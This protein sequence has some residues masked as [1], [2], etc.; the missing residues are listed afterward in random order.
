[1]RIWRVRIACWIPKATDTQLEHVICIF[2]TATMV[3]R[4]RLNVTLPVLFVTC[5]TITDDVEKVKRQENLKEV[6]QFVCASCNCPP[7]IFSVI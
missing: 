4:M 2:S 3:A 5:V 6:T 7:S 1:M